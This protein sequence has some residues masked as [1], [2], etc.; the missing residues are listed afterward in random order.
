MVMVV[1]MAL[2]VLVVMMKTDYNLKSKGHFI[3]VIKLIA[4]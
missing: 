4:E 2:V 1:V 3:S